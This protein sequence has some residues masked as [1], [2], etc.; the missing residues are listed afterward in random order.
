MNKYVCGVITSLIILS[1]FAAAGISGGQEAVMV[2]K[3]VAVPPM[4]AGDLQSVNFTK[5]ELSPRYGNLRLQPGESK[6][7][8]ITIKNKEKKAVSVKPNTVIPPYG[9]YMMDK[10]WVTVTPESAE[11]PAGESRKFLLKA[12]V[13][14]DAS[15]G[16][17]NAQ[18]AFTD[19]VIPAPYQP[20]PNYVHSFSLSLDVWAQ[21]TVQI[22][23]PYISDQLEAG[24]EYDYEIKL[25]NKGDKA[26]AIDPRISQEGGMY[27][28]YGLV[29]PAFPDSA[30]TITAPG[31]IPAGAAESVK[32]HIKVPADAKGRYSGMI[33][34][35]I[36]DPSLRRGGW[37]E[38][39]VNLNFNI[40]KQ[41][42][43]PFVR[44]FT[45]KQ[46]SPVT[47]E[48]SSSY[49]GDLYKLA[50]LASG[51]GTKSAKEPS[52]E[53]SLDGP[54]GK[55]ELKLQ[56][57]VIKGGV[58][59]GGEIPPWEMD[60]IGIYQEM[61]TQYIETYTFNASAGEWKLKVLPR[62]TERFEYTITI[63]G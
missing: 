42:A 15:A 41:P 8:T 2:E 27:G 14:K 16:Y 6:E 5:L 53:T 21:P 9:E 54:E 11:I 30:I 44:S 56:K 37:P 52:F 1:M 47:I 26:V 45:L 31:S 61:G 24:K 35:G 51:M 58:S 20:F 40:W 12:S 13:P 28:P 19:E 29:E 43:E 57:T 49:F 50:M 7:L 25:K 36:D 32:I 18:V 63:G 33:D 38:G 48:I 39:R 17:Y 62:N 46:A 10:E 3:A 59:M 34:L 55:T 60:S 23:T 4:P 22:T